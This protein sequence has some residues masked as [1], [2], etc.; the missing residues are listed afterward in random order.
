MIISLNF[1]EKLKE[2]LFPFVRHFFGEAFEHFIELGF[3]GLL[4]KLYFGLHW[5]NL[6][7]LVVLIIILSIFKKAYYKEDMFLAFAIM[8]LFQENILLGWFLFIYISYFRGITGLY[9][10]ENRKSE[11]YS[12]LKSRALGFIGQYIAPFLLLFVARKN[13]ELRDNLFFLTFLWFLHHL[14]YYILLLLDVL[15]HKKDY[16]IK[17]VKE[18]FSKALKD[19]KI[20]FIITFVLFVLFKNLIITFVYKVVSWGILDYLF[21]ALSWLI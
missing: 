7:A 14:N 6:V 12:V 20:N 10:E 17:Q 2:K 9:E 11:K 4:L 13:K 3:W 8:M 18:I 19:T 5:K 21:E 16:T 15:T 1:R